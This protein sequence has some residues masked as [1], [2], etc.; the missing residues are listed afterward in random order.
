MTPGPPGSADDARGG[1]RTTFEL[2][3]RSPEG[4][5]FVG[6]VT[7]LRLCV[8]HG[9]LG[10]LAHHAPMLVALDCGVTE[11]EHPDGDRERIALG[12]GFARVSGTVVKLTVQFMDYPLDIDQGRAHQAMARAPGPSPSGST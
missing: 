12:D 9:Y 8:P 10:V 5:L 11:G 7:A 4:L 1:G 3:V 2:R 6:P